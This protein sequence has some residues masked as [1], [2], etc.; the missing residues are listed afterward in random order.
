MNK[1]YRLTVR[2]LLILAII[3]LLYHVPVS[4]AQTEALYPGILDR[5]RAINA[6]AQ[7][8]PVK[9]PDADT[10]DVDMHKWGQIP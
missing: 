9:Y 7:V 8:T 4:M 3:I 10:V 2:Q 1:K 6:A 5:S